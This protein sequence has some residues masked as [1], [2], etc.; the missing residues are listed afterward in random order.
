MYVLI[1]YVLVFPIFRWFPDFSTKT[2]TSF[3]FRA[4]FWVFFKFIGWEFN[5]CM[6]YQFSHEISFP[7][8]PGPPHHCLNIL[9]VE[10]SLRPTFVTTLIKIAEVI[11][12][13]LANHYNELILA[14][15]RVDF[16]HFQNIFCCIYFDLKYIF[17]AGLVNI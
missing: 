9:T 10:E 7:E 3:R 8:F 12:K 13:S 2:T 14:N 16:Q 1:K 15:I 11:T 6:Y 4:T 5:Q 17:D